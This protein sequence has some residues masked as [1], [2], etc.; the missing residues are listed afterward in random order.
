MPRVSAVFRP[1]HA[2]ATDIFLKQFS[3]IRYIRESETCCKNS[4]ED[5]EYNFNNSKVFKKN[6]K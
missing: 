4:R 1:I 6:R 2:L 3:H 5:S